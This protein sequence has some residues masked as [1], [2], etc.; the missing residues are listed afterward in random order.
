MPD[1]NDKLKFISHNSYWCPQAMKRLVLILRS[2]AVGLLT[3][4]HF[5]ATLMWVKRDYF[6]IKKKLKERF[7]IIELMLYQISLVCS[8]STNSFW[9][10]SAVLVF[11]Q[12][13]HWEKWRANMDK[14]GITETFVNR[15]R[16]SVDRSLNFS[17][18]NKC[19]LR[20]RSM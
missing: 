10:V 4:Y 17:R 13:L 18:F 19:K 20:R 16:C 8:I 14:Q 15:C 12:N 9:I 11:F 5:T 1:K 7:V 6:N 2:H 3:H